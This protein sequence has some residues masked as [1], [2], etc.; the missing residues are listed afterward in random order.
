MPDAL[1]S[2]DQVAE[3]LG[4]HPK[5]LR[6][7][8]PELMARAPALHARKLGRSILFTEQDYALILEALK[9]R[10]VSASA[11]KSG[12]RAARS[13]SAGKPSTSES[14]AQERLRALL[15]SKQQSGKPAASRRTTLTVLPGGRAA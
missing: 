5:T 10:S 8:L 3:R 4:R 14:S 6:R 15:Q 2:L 13:A 11:A 12:T 7:M 9:W 1:L